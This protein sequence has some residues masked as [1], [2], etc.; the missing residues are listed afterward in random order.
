MSWWS[1]GEPFDEW[2]GCEHCN[3]NERP[4]K[5]TCD[6]CKSGDYWNAMDWD[7]IEKG[8]DDERTIITT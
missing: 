8:A 4:S 1:D 7:E 3:F 5:R 6:G 2:E